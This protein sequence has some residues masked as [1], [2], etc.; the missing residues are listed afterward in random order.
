M[1]K[2]GLDVER[3]TAI[4]VAELM[5]VAAR[6]AP[7]GCG[8]DNLEVRL[9]DG[10]EK[11]AL[12]E[13]MRRAG[14]ETSVDFFVRD[15]NNVDT[16]IVVLLFGA[17]I[18]PIFCPNCGFCGYKDC[19]ENIDHNGICM[20]NVVDLGIALG[21]AATVAAAHKIDNRILFSAGKAALNLGYFP[22]D[23][24]IAY[25]IPLS[26]S[27]KSPFFDREGTCRED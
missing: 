10:A 2:N 24:T 25:G 21:S 15:G 11:D 7:K 6:T 17:R 22:E 5:A 1:L 3:Q 27:S 14:K 9:V 18:S 19:E 23:V 8:I 4:Q 16:A 13:E 12:G 26:I 20:F